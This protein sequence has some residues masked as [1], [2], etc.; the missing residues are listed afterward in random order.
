MNKLKA[1]AKKYGYVVYPVL[2]GVFPLMSFYGANASEIKSGD[3]NLSTFLVLNLIVV[4]FCWVASFLILRNRR[5]A[6]ILTVVFLVLF[7]MFG[8][9]HDQIGDFAIN[10]PITPL[11]PTK[12]LL[13]GSAVAVILA[14][15]F[16]R[17]ISAE[18]TEKLNSTL[19]T[20]AVVM[21]AS[22]LIT[23][24]PALF[25]N[26]K[27][28]G[29]S[30]PKNTENSVASA[31]TN[32]QD[33][34]DVYYILLDGY[35]RED[36][37]KQDFNHDNS[38]FTG[39]L[40]S[41]GFY[42]A[43]KANSNY[44]HTH[45]SV[46]STFNMKY[47]NYLSEEMGED[48][49]DRAPLKDLMQNNEV[50]PIFKQLGYKYVNIGSQ[51]GWTMQSPYSD[52]DIK[53]KDADSKILNIELD[54]FALV[55]LQTTALKP[56]I[57][58]SIRGNLLSRVLGAFE[59]TNKVPAIKE[60]TFTFTHIL[61]PHPPY[62]FDRDG[63]I[64]GQTDLEILNQGFSDREKYVDQTI[65]VNKLVLEM[66]DNI[67]KNSERPPIIIIASDHGPASSLGDADFSESD[68]AKFDKEG[69]IER[70]GILNA[71][72]FPDQDYSKLYE[73]ITPVNS[74]RLV[75]SKY[76][77]REDLSLLPDQSYFSNNKTNE[78]LMH[79]VTD[80]LKQQTNSLQQ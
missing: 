10:T 56:W 64:P 36:L 75:L 65:Y 40:K 69:I 59:R 1:F 20:V 67:Q 41:K 50:V 17:R 52:I 27:S 12:I 51:W 19:S 44:A 76:F 33:L 6:S 18:R 68:P 28:S 62:L 78:Y 5:K 15:L 32:K 24:L 7:F 30:E 4:F 39:S 77:G 61:S 13:L 57:A 48:S 66:V 55:Y 14:W 3:F 73:S 35:A 26:D 2:F 58:N 43:D 72:Y 53:A 80:L 25:S 47:L 63:V 8:R 9:A 22:T 49:T 60:P 29:S 54:E 46:P 79:D 71:Y 23:V 70:M 42:V 11:G 45:F 21:V 34:P 31:V 16:I 38:G 74:F 37:L